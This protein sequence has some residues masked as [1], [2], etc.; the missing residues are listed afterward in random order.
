[1]KVTISLIGEQPIPNLLPLRYQPPDVAVLVHTDRTRRVAQR[2]EEL[3]APK[4]TVR[5][6]PTDPYDNSSSR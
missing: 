6:L 4:V 5:L 2:L 3:L 1:M